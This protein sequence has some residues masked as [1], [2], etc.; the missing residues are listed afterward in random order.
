[1]RWAP[2]GL[3][4][5]ILRLVDAI[6]KQ[7]AAKRPA[8]PARHLILAQSADLPPATD[9]EGATVYVRDVG[10]G[11]AVMAFSDGT[12]WRRCDTLGAL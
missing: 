12:S 5:P 10:G 9:Y 8:E 11:V 6:D 1:M 7:F 4:A 3:P 2:A